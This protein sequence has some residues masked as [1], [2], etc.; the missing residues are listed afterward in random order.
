MDTEETAACWAGF[1]LFVV[2]IALW[3]VL[4]ELILI[5]WRM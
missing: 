4:G 3:C 2:L 5:M 1:A